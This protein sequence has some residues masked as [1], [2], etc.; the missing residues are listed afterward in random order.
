M[1]TSGRSSELAEV[2]VSSE[3]V[4]ARVSD[5]ALLDCV[6]AVEVLWV[7]CASV[8]CTFVGVVSSSASDFHFL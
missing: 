2:N 5:A 1:G 4:F 3:G 6:P 7:G 8:F